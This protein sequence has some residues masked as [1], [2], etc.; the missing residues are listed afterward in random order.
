MRPETK[1]ALDEVI[2]ANAWEYARLGPAVRAF[3][4]AAEGDPDELG[5]LDAISELAPSVSQVDAQASLVREALRLALRNDRLDEAVRALA[6]PHLGHALAKVTSEL[7]A[8]DARYVRMLT[9]LCQGSERGKR[10][11][12]FEAFTAANPEAIEAIVEAA[13]RGGM[14]DTDCATAFGWRSWSAALWR[15]L[16][17]ALREGSRET[18]AVAAQRLAQWRPD[19]PPEVE[20]ALRAAL[21]DADDVVARGAA[22]GCGVR[23]ARRGLEAVDTLA[24]APRPAA[25]LAAMRAIECGDFAPP[26]RLARALRLCADPDEQTRTRARAYVAPGE[27]PFAPDAEVCAAVAALAPSLGSEPMWEAL[28]ARLAALAVDA[29]SARALLDALPAEA[30]GLPFARLR[31]A[32]ERESRGENLRPCP[33]C[34]KLERDVTTSEL[35]KTAEA[36]LPPIPQGDKRATLHACPSCGALYTHAC[37]SRW[38]LV[39]EVYV[40]LARLSYARALSQLD[41]AERDALTAQRDER[42]RLWHDRLGHPHAWSR[43]DAAWNLCELALAEKRPDELVQ[44]LAHED[45]SVRHEA[46]LAFSRAPSLV[47]PSRALLDALAAIARDDEPQTRLIARAHLT[48]RELAAKSV[49]EVVEQMLVERD[50][51][52]QSALVLALGKPDAYGHARWLLTPLRSSHKSVREAAT[53]VLAQ[54]AQAGALDADL[55]S[56]LCAILREAD[57]GFLDEGVTDAVFQVFAKVTARHDEVVPLVARTVTPEHG[58]YALQALLTQATLGAPLGQHAL[59][60]GAA[61]N[62]MALCDAAL[63]LLRLEFARSGDAL[64]VARALSRALGGRCRSSVVGELRAVADRGA[65]LS[66]LDEVLRASLR[67]ASSYERDILVRVLVSNAAH[68]AP[69]DVRPWVGHANPAVVAAAMNEAAKRKIDAAPFAAE[70]S[71]ARAF[72]VSFVTREADAWLAAARTRS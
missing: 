12:H 1:K 16:L 19:E 47:A 13:K 29:A 23:A 20:P 5:L 57:A 11:E 54:A 52:R 62:T 7:V 60:V 24:I 45:R 37:D 46:L 68:R 48:E 10:A 43:R 53:R 35:P 71:A 65:D 15:W 21:D 4:T 22:E 64:L 8:E 67:G 61:A 44:L 49:D 32:L 36:L 40:D 55:R 17:S 27:A 30:P 33:V 38:D 58:Y 63:Q 31:R 72:G 9:P 51:G 25:R 2:C 6:G 39:E 50:P 59:A 14:S 66:P 69:D 3:V 56:S 28:E 34:S 70:L 42:L 26:S 41:G 18:R